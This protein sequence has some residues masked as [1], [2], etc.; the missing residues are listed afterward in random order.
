ATLILWHN[1]RDYIVTLDYDAIMR[2]EK[3]YHAGRSIGRLAFPIFCFLLTE[4]FFHTKSRP[5]YLLRL[6]V[7]ALASEHAFNLL[8]SGTNL[9]PYDQNVFLTL[10]ISLITIMLIDKVKDRF[11]GKPDIVSVLTI[12]ITGLG[13]L[14]AYKLNTDYDYKGVLA[15]TIMYLLHGSRILTCLGTALAFTWE[16]WAITA[17]GP[18]LLYNGKRG[19]S[20]K[21]F[22]YIFYPLH[23]YLIYF[24]AGTISGH[25]SF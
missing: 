21:Y 17:A 22:F 15:V 4:G 7:M 20:I 13:C 23:I 1:F 9:D 14:L 19:L 3:I 5:K 25:F 8:V 16:P 18:I 12:V 11:T 2:Y 10:A 24:L 6:M